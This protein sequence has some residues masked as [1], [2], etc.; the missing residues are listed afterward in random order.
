M[1]GGGR[2][3][4]G[5][6]GSWA[7]RATSVEVGAAGWGC[8]HHVFAGRSVTSEAGG[9]GTLQTARGRESSAVHAAA[10]L[11][12][13]PPARQP[14]FAAA[15]DC[16]MLSQ[17]TRIW[18]KTAARRCGCT[19]TLLTRPRDTR[20]ITQPAKLHV[21]PSPGAEAIR[22]HAVAT[23]PNISRAGTRARQPSRRQSRGGSGC[24]RR[25]WR[26][27]AGHRRPRNHAAAFMSRSGRV[28]CGSAACSS[29]DQGM[30]ESDTVVPAK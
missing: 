23:Q 22:R 26:P 21:V 9:D 14:A 25:R 15:A 29:G 30:W 8:A 27:A 17:N 1:G 28:T 7:R 3:G 19:C 20:S 16:K 12:S 18:R 10:A 13:A 2:G 4:G 11:C 6:M 5:G 24:C